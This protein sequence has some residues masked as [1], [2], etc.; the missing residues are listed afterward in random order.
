MSVSELGRKAN[1][2]SRYAFLKALH[3]IKNKPSND[4][5]S[6]WSIASVNGQPFDKERDSSSS[7]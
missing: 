7:I 4:E 5:D 3:K 1:N 2:N 6:F